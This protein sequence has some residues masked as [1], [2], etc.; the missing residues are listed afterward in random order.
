MERVLKWSLPALILVNV[1]LVWSGVLEAGTAIMVGATIELLVALIAMRQV[2][3]AIRR[4]HRDRAAGLDIETAVEDGIAVIFPR[5]VARVVALEPRIWIALFKWAFRRRSLAPNEFSYHKRSAMGAFLALVLMTLP[6]ELL[7]YEILIPWPIVR[8][9]LLVVSVYAVFWLL[10]LFA[11]LRVLP[12]RLDAGGLRIRYGV[13]ADGFVPY[14]IISAVELQRR[15]SPDQEGLR[16]E[17]EEAAAYLA[18]GGRTDLTLH[19]REPIALHGL[20]KPHP[21]VRTIHLAADRPD[22]LASELR[23]RAGVD[24]APEVA[25]ALAL[26]LAM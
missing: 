17:E 9:I 14:D 25:P 22:A 24:A 5:T 13:L 7:L 8:W 21:P 20:L 26:P 19:L 10:G 12:Y 6:V 11:S 15:K 2:V 3:V 1:T 23:T 18:A 16:V 4:Y